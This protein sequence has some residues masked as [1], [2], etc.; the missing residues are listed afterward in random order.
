[1]LLDR[2]GKNLI[3]LRIF[4]LRA[5]EGQVKCNRLALLQGT[6]QTGMD[7]TPPGPDSD[8]LKTFIIDGHNDDFR[9]S[10][11]VL[12][13]LDGYIV[14]TVIKKG[15]AFGNREQGGDAQNE[16]ADK[17]PFVTIAFFYGLHA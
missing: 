16:K 12:G 10:R 15:K 14:K 4:G 11:F 5:Q 1:M 3:V 8:F 7:G 2:I 17:Q 9:G 13:K 6:K